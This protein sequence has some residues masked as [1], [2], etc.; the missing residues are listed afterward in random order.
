M[1]REV[2]L[3]TVTLESGS[4]DA[5]LF[6]SKGTLV[7]RAKGTSPRLYANSFGPTIWCKNMFS[8]YRWNAQF[9]RCIWT[10]STQIFK[11]DNINKLNPIDEHYF[12][13]FVNTNCTELKRMIRPNIRF[14]T[15]WTKYSAE[16][17]YSVEPTFGA[18]LVYMYIN[19]RETL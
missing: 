8:G 4:N 16:H 6:W 12:S 15:F 2:G 7:F 19:S 3:R 10:T 18:S 11:N 14:G 13:Q 5:L 17:S 9:E 1:S